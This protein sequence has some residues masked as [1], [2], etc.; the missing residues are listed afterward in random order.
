MGELWGF[1]EGFAG[2]K[3]GWPRGP[4]AWYLPATA[5]G[6]ALGVRVR[7]TQ[8]GEGD[9]S[10]SPFL[11]SPWGGAHLHS[12]SSGL[13]ASLCSWV[14]GPGL[15]HILGKTLGLSLPCSGPGITAPTSPTTYGTLTVCWH[16]ANQATCLRT[17]VPG[18]VMT[19]IR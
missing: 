3:T 1:P 7:H 6:V 17:D 11:G 12:M 2:G 5:S 18:A 14:R 16:S 15:F 4:A 10:C 19:P 13:R 9:C 8:E